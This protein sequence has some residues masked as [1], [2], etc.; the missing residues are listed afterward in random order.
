MEPA[1]V[2]EEHSLEIEQNEHSVQAMSGTYTRVGAVVGCQTFRA[3]ISL[4]D[5][6]VVVVTECV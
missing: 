2:P 5:V 1:Y 3:G 6:I 4:G